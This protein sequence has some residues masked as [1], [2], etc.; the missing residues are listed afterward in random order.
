MSITAII[1]VRKGSKGIP[2]KGF[3][4]IAGRPLIYHTIDCCLETP[5]INHVVITTD[6]TDKISSLK[7]WYR[8]KITVV[9]R[10]PRAA[11]DTATS[12]MALLDCLSRIEKPELIVFAQCTSPLTEPKDL[13]NL[14][15]QV[16]DL[17]ADSA[18]FYAHDYRYYVQIHNLKDVGIPRQDREPLI[19]IAGNAWCFKTEGFLKHKTRFFGE[20]ALVQIDEY[21]TLEI[22]DEYDWIMTQALLD[23][24]R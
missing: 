4:Y 2:N 24:R 12:E 11:T 9:P 20:A 16:K 14:I 8:D 5:D 13:T 15:S 22:D 23:N 19:R 10:D 18:G 1:P 6:A 7:Y 21:K 3:K 17:G